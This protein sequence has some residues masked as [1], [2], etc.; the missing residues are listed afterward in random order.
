YQRVRFLRVVNGTKDKVTVYLQ[1]HAPDEDSWAWLPV[2]PQESDDSL[3]FEIDPGQSLDLTDDQWR[4]AANR[5]M[6]WAESENQKW[7]EFKDNQLWVVPEVTSS[8]K[9]R[10]QSPEIQ[11]YKIEIR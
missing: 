5:L 9:H 1:Y 7:D 11:T 10:Y 6:V 2:D 3:I 8:G 4:I